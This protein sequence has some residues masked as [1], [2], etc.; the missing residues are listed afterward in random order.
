MKMSRLIFLLLMMHFLI[1][2][3]TGKISGKIIDARSG[4]PLIGANVL[5]EQSEMG[6]ATDLNRGLYYTKYPSRYHFCK[7]DDDW[8]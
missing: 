1:S 8:L 7:S 5:I 2:G 3:T 6:T 4:D